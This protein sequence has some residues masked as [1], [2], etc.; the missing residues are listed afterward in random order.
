[1]TDV[2][3]EVFEGSL[4]EVDTECLLLPVFQDV[5]TTDP[6][7]DL[8]A[9]CGGRIQA[10]LS[11]RAFSGKKRRCLSVPATD[12]IGADEII[13]VGLGKSDGLDAHIVREAL[14]TAF[15]VA[16]RRNASRVSVGGR[17][18]LGT[19]AELAAVATEALLL[20]EYRFTR[21]KPAPNDQTSI[22]EL[23]V[24]AGD[25][26]MEAIARSRAI[27]AGVVWARDLVN[28]SPSDKRPPRFAQDV[29]EVAESV[30]LACT[31]IDED[32]A[33]EL[34]MSALLAVGRGSTAAPRLVI[35][36]HAPAGTEGTAPVCIV[37]KGVTF[38]TGGISIKPSANMDHMK[39]DMGGA[40]AVAGTMRAVAEI[41][42]PR[43]IVGLIPMA[44]NMPDGDAYRPG[45]LVEALNGKVI[46][47]LNTDAEGRMILADALAY[48]VSEFEPSRVVDL[49]TLTGAC[50]VALGEDIAGVMANDDE[51]QGELVAAGEAVGERVWPLP[52]FDI[53]DR[54]IKSKVGDIKNTG[55]RW[56]GAIT[57]AKFLENFVDETPWAHL[58]IAGPAY[59]TKA[60]PLAPAGG[61]GFGVRLMVH[62]LSQAD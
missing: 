28:T 45:D 18:E 44:E 60:Q 41:N 53:Y 43:R 62:W 59:R 30:G 35:L 42:V 33:A 8:D 52:M 13:L 50:V 49:A 25:G 12:G 7:D 14:A 31:V 11:S 10:A 34:G 22:V 9:A 24:P 61:V 55:G 4:T 38:D 57:A 2:R 23:R 27:G 56:G 21:Y 3:I 40:A 1:M 20:G 58:D 37:G 51:L 5:E 26:A 16:R 48:G 32:Q 39:S 36:E 46:E 19:A 29:Q 17:P 47:V 6:F 54:L 15:A